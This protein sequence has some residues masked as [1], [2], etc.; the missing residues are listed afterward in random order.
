[1][2]VVQRP[3]DVVVQKVIN[4]RVN[5]DGFIITLDDLHANAVLSGSFLVHISRYP[6]TGGN[7]Q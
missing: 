1:M 7:S 6:R 5:R 3:T 2:Q 4:E